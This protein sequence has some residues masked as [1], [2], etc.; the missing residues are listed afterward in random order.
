MAGDSK[1]PIG[2]PDLMAENNIAITGGDAGYFDLMRDCVGSLRATPEGRAMA[3]G[4]VDCGLTA[5]QCAWF[6]GQG[7]LLVEAQWDFDFPG[8]DKLKDGYKGTTVRP[9]LPR[10]FPGFD[11]YLWLDGD[12][13][14]QQGDAVA[15]LLRAA[16]TGALAVV[17]EIHRSMRHYHHAW[18]E[19]SAI[20]GA[21]YESCFGKQV[22]ERLIRYPMIN[23]G[24]FALS[25]DAPHW[26]GWADLMNDTLQ[27]STSMTDQLT[28]NVLVYDQG[29]PYEPM[30]CR[31]NWTI[32][33]AT[34]AWDAE[35]SLF[36][37]PAMPYDPLGILHLTIYTKNLATMDVREL[38]GPHDG[39]VRA[40]SLR[41]P[42]RTAI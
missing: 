36:V 2:H 35:R 31:C 14:I 28:L 12:T 24:V 15:L 33:H 5:E 11:L 40:R 26:A 1:G 19:F 16:R 4:I 37:E 18:G 34:P 20:C 27:R 32:H 21:A 30:P 9:F 13:W 41:W 23:D 7:A 22:A 25:A 42:G 10:Y 17:P 6:R 39:Q 29:F 38:G 8:R 3:L